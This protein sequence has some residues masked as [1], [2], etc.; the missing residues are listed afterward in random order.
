[1]TWNPFG[2]WRCM[3][4]HGG[5]DHRGQWRR[6]A[7]N[8]QIFRERTKPLSLKREKKKKRKERIL[9]KIK[10]SLFIGVRK[11]HYFNVKGFTCFAVPSFEICVSTHSDPINPLTRWLPYQQLD[12]PTCLSATRSTD[13]IRV[14][15]NCWPDP[16]WPL[17]SYFWI[18]GK[19]RKNSKKI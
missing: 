9:K 5:F 8:R 4:A 3:M 18:R 14:L 11:W 10:K 2:A 7:T 15:L 6:E 17:F 13:Q 19:S 16:V 12:L 1:M